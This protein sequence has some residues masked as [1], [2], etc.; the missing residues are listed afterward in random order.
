MEK[1]MIIEDDQTMVSLLTILFEMD[2]YA[3]SAVAPTEPIL[4]R[5]REENPAII[6]MD[7]NLRAVDGL[8]ILA[9]IRLSS[10][11]RDT[12]VIMSSGMNVEERCMA[13]GAN[14]FLLK[15]YL[16]EELNSSIVHLLK[17]NQGN[18]NTED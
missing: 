12:P 4:E 1:I 14:A 8:A 15:P 2:G 9:D 7:V 6:L 13:Y 17:N 16:P 5:I 18:S 11:L 10:D 3:V